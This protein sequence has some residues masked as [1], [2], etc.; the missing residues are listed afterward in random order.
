MGRRFL[1]LLCAVV[2]FGAGQQAPQLPPGFTRTEIV[3]NATVL[4]ARIKMAPGAREEVHTHPFSAVV[5][6]IGAANVDLRMGD[7]HTTSRR[8]HGVV[9]YI[10]KELPHAAAN[11]GR[12]PLDFVTIAIKADRRPGGEAP[13]TAAPEGITRTPVLD[14]ADARV[15]GVS[16]APSAREPVHTH[17]YDLVVVQ[18]TPGRVEVRLGSDVTTKDYAAGDV[19]FLPRDVPH[20]VSNLGARP[21][22]VLS[23][24]IK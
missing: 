22:D 19:I 15:T 18:L 7:V 17:P 16:F 8:E 14:N 6:Q 1:G 3:N 9:D 10:P 4:V 24:G 23:V 12:D 13:A 5:V 11:A 2:V 20:A 21:F